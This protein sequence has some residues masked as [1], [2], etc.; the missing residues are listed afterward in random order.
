MGRLTSHS[1]RHHSGKDDEENGEKEGADVVV[2][3][4]GIVAHAE[5]EDPHEETDHDVCSHSNVQL[6]LQA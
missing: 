5:E 6:P 4:Q 1:G 2:H 3:L